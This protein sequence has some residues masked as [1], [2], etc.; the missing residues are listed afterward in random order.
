MLSVILRYV[1]SQDAFHF[2]LYV[3]TYDLHYILIAKDIDYVI[4]NI[5]QLTFWNF[6]CSDGILL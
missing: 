4:G 6:Y 1:T 5:C 2:S 3:V